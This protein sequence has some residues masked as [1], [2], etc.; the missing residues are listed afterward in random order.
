M[1]LVT[2]RV[3]P[4]P[5]WCGTVLLARASD[6][7]SGAPPPPDCTAD[8]GVGGSAVRVRV[9]ARHTLHIHTPDSTTHVNY[10]HTRRHMLH[11]K[12]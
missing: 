9:S 3:M 7:S 4:R 12:K 11:I 6:H 2:H 1:H 5:V 8:S 10:T